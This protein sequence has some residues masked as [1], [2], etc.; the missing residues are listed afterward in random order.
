MCPGG[1]IVPASTSEN[2]QVV[3]GMSSSQRHTAFA[4]SGIVVETRIEDLTEY[5]SY[6][7]LAG[8]RYQQHVE[9]LASEYGGGNQIA[10]AQ[11]T[12]DF[13]NGHFSS[14][15]PACSYLPKIVSSP[16]HSWLPQPITR[17]L[18]EAF[19]IYER[20]MRGF[21]TSE[22]LIV[23]VE[24]RSS[25]P[26]RIPRDPVTWEHVQLKGL[27]PCGEGSGYAGGITSSAIDGEKAAECVSRLF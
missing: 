19:K 18:Q 9:R 12:I 23:G 8:L 13:V 14:S 17:R 25:S 21:L 22:S 15:L 26:V 1:Y 5:R 6:R 11:R 4:N 20:K 2:Q 3:N 27:F 24:S 16:L 10:P 7:V